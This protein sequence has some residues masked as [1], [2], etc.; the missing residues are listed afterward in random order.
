MKLICLTCYN[1]LHSIEGGILL[2]DKI[3][4]MI[5]PFFISL[6]PAFNG[7]YISARA[8]MGYAAGPGV[9]GQLLLMKIRQQ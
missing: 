9:R 5:L 7:E 8:V 1:V 2:K 3:D 4:A 6:N